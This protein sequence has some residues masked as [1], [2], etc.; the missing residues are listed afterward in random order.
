MHLMRKMSRPRPET[1]DISSGSGPEGVRLQ[2]VIAAAGL[3]SRRGAEELIAAGR[4][5]INGRGATLGAKVDPDRDPGAV[6]G[7]GV[8]IGPALVYQA[9]N[10]PR[11]MLSAMSST[12]ARPCVGDL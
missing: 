6:D 5:T 1:A 8:P 4:V 2:K 3:A 7:V 11:G 12:S 10:K 9:A